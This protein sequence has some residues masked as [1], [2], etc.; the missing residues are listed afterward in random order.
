MTRIDQ[1][2]GVTVNPKNQIPAAI[3]GEL[4]HIPQVWPEP[5]VVN[6]DCDDNQ[7]ILPDNPV[8]HV[9]LKLLSLPGQRICNAKRIGICGS[10]NDPPVHRLGH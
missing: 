7:I 2:L 5:D 8:L 10:I 6:V 3:Q 9:S 1:F 4:H